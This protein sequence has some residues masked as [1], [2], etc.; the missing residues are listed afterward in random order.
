VE[1]RKNNEL[2]KKTNLGGTANQKH[3]VLG[4]FVCAS[5]LGLFR[6]FDFG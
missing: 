4:L 5:D 6:R 3:I 1:K 2:K